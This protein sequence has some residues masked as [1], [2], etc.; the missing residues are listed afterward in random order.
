L[1]YF[2]EDL[3]KHVI[4]Q[5]AKAIEYLHETSGV[6]H[7]YV[8]VSS[9]R[10]NTTESPYSDIKPEN[11]LFLPA[12][13][14]PSKN[15]KPQQP[16]DED[17]EDEGEFT[18]NF[19]SGGIGEIKIADFGLSKVIWDTRTGTPCGTVGYTAPEIVKDEQYSK[20]VD[21]W[22]MGCVLYTLLCG[23]PPFCDESIQILTKKIACGQ[24]I[25]LSPW[26]D[27]ISK[28]ARD[29][30][31]H[32]LVVD[33]KK[34][35]NIKEFMEHPW[36][37]RADEETIITAEVPLLAQLHG[38]MS[39]TYPQPLKDVVVDQAPCQPVSAHILSVPSTS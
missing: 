1:T 28:P 11:I 33:P 17:K 22:A 8:S 21:M 36:I 10:L 9:S 39:Q 16:G 27:H 38:Q 4:V 26:W 23:F 25:F 6:V 2:S 32:L 37:C 12:P 20:G 18:S 30:V 13:F 7:R 29:L 35:Y 5:V 34:R 15:P 14:T 3:S 31:S 19:G 24:F